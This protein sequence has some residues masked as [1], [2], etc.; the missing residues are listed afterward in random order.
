VAQRTEGDHAGSWGLYAEAE[1][2]W[3]GVVFASE[4]EARDLLM[5]MLQSR[6]RLGS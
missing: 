1:R 5:Q 3:M 6:S 2:K 4:K